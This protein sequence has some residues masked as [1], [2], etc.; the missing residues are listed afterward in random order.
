M[1]AELPLSTRILLVRLSMFERWYHMDDVYLSLVCFL[2]G[3][4]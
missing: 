2:K 3:S 4:E 1:S